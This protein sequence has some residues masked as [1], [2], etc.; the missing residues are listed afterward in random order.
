MSTQSLLDRELSTF[1]A[2]LRELV[3]ESLGK[4]AVVAEDRILGV[5]GSYEE[6]LA[7]GYDAIG[8]DRPF[9]VRQVATSEPVFHVFG[10]SVTAC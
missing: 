5:W 10:G 3:A 2:H 9:L 6:A 1:N 7:A 8:V 4:Y